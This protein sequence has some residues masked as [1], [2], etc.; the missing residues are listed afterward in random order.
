ML[1]AAYNTECIVQVALKNNWAK[2]DS[3]LGD[4]RVI[5]RP[6]SQRASGRAGPALQ[7]GTPNGAEGCVQRIK[8]SNY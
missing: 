1:D 3:S 7:T 5:F 8:P 6:H 4:V 2:A